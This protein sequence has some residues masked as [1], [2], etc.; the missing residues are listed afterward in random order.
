MAARKDHGKQGVLRENA[1]TANGPDEGRP[2]PLHVIKFAE[3]AAAPIENVVR[4]D[5]NGE[6]QEQSG[7]TTRVRNG[8]HARPPLKAGRRT[9]AA[10][11]AAPGRLRTSS[12]PF[13][14]RR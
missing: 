11:E 7:D 4:R 9:L 13:G 12:T 8:H 10:A 5:P 2:I 14:V 6:T 3:H 1:R